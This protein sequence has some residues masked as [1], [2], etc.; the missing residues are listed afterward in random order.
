MYK[1]DEAEKSTFVI[2]RQ[3]GL[4]KKGEYRGRKMS[5]LFEVS[6]A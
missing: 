4:I 3:R 1:S 6:H 2:K 5:S